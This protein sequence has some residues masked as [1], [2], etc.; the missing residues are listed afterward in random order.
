MERQTNSYPTFLSSMVP[1]IE[2]GVVST[3]YILWDF[4]A[5]G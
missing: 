3:M 5:D 1:N 4:L 2:L